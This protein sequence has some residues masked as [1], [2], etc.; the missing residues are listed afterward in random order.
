M[1][2][3][4]VLGYI[5]AISAAGGG[6]VPDAVA[7]GL[8][9]ALNLDYRP[10]ATKICIWIGKLLHSKTINVSDFALQEQSDCQ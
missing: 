1:T 3:I 4:A 9:E 5:E 8:Y 7:D 10:Q 2:T 6:D